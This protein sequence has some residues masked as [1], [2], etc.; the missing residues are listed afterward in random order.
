VYRRAAVATTF[1]PRFRAVLAEA[2]RLAKLLDVPIDL[3]HADE[4]NP[5]KEARFATAMSELGLPAESRVHFEPGE[6]VRSI[7]SVQER[8][9][10]DLLIAG[11]L[12]RESVHRNFTG[13][14]A[15][16]LLRQAAC[17][18]F[19]FVK[20]EETPAELSHVFVAIP[21][22]SEHSRSTYQ[23]GVNFSEK[24]G[25]TELTLL[26]VQT[27]FA[28]AKEKGKTTDPPVEESLAEFVADCGSE[29]V[30]IDTHQVRGNTGFTACE[31]IQSAGADLLILP[32]HAIND[33]RPPFEPVLDWIIQVIP[34]NVW[35]IRE[36]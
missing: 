1:S 29:T 8:I 12:E 20:P 26:H 33:R 16:E 28:E 3:I 25:V 24:I 13:N 23:Q 35:V 11:A 9:D 30:H 18:L 21:N 10:I 15:R 4:S 14:V 36:R 5:E 22:F 32:S 6:P 2:D 34:S 31:Y 7:L 19:L 27:T 17:D